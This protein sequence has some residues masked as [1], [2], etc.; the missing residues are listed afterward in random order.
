MSKVCNVCGLEKE[1]KS[2]KAHTCNDCLGAGL[3][4]C[5]AC[6]SCNSSKSGTELVEWYTSQSFCSKNRLQAIIK[7]MDASKI[8]G[9]AK[10]HI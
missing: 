5:P 10:C 2:W 8:G 3:K 1:P 6:I 7:Y 9:G 4:W